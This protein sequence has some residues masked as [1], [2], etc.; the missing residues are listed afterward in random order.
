MAD[1][2]MTLAAQIV[3]AHVAANDVSADE[4]PTLIREVYHALS[5]VGQTPAEP[6]KPVSPV[7][8]K[9]SVFADRI[10]CLDC[11]QSFMM[12]KR[13]ISS[14]HQMTPE[15]YRAKWGLPAS[16]S[17]VAA[18]YAA[19]R[20]KLA[21]ASGL[22]RKAEAPAPPKKRG[23]P[24]KNK[25]RLRFG[26]RAFDVRKIQRR[27]SATTAGPR[28]FVHNASALHTIP[29]AFWR[30]SRCRCCVP[31]DLGLALGKRVFIHR[32]GREFASVIRC[33]TKDRGERLSDRLPE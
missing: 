14:D 21:L 19:T 17:M 31:L 2:I 22:G 29:P 28:G 24:A 10:L 32:F 15:E 7:D 25:W 33:V 23:R 8:V 26:R 20:S 9:K 30:R 6:I 5:T 27:R 11:G 4:L 18:S 3:S 13:H 12:H 1:Q 16:Y